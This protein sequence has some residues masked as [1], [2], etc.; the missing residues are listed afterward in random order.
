MK[1]YKYLIIMKMI[2]MLLLFSVVQLQAGSFA[3]TVRIKKKNSPIV[4]VFREIKKQTGYTVLCKSEII[5]N[6]PNVSV[7]FNN[8]SLDRALNELLSPRGLNY[9]KEGN[10]IIV[11]A[12]ENSGIERYAPLTNVGWIAE[13]SPV[14]GKITD[15]D[16]KVLAGVSVAV[17]GGKIATASDANGNY[18]IAASRGAILVFSFVG[19]ERKEVEVN[20]D[21]LNVNMHPSLSN[22]EEVVVTGY[23]TF[24]KSDY[25]GSASTIRTERMSD[26]PAVDFSTMLQGNAPGV[27]VNSLSGQ[28]GGS[29][30]IRIRGM[31]SINAVNRPLFVIDGVPVMSGDISSSSSNNAGLDVMSTLSNADI[32][33]ITV[34]KDAAAASLYG[35]RAAGGVILITTKSGKAG[36]PVFSFKGDYGLSSQATDFREVMNG[37]QRREML[38][39]GLRNKARYID[40]LTDETLIENFAQNNIDKYAPQPWSGWTD[41]KKELFRRNS[42]FRNADLSA[43][44]GDSKVS[45]YTSLGYTNQTGLS[46]QSGFERLT[47]RLNVKY[48]MSDKL[49]LGANIL[50]S[51]VNQDV[52]SEGGTYTSPIYS[53]RHKLTASE[54]VYNEDG[55]FFLDFFSNGPRNPK[56]SSLYNYRR[57]KADRS[58]N[59][60]FANYKFMDGLVFNTTF[61]LDHTTTRYNSWSDPRTSDG[62]KTNG[63]LSTSFTDYNQ[64]VWRNSLTYTKTFATKHHLDVLGGYEVNRYRRDGMDGAKD[65][66]PSVEK[67]VLSNG[68]VLTDLSGSNTEWRLLSYLSRVNY[69]YN[70]KY[71]L[72]GSVR[73]DGSSRIHRSSRWGTFWSLSGAWKFTKENFMASLNDVLTDGKLRVSYGTNGTLPSSYFTYMDLTGFGFPYGNNPGIRETQIGNPNLRWEKQ[74]NL[75]IGLDVRLFDRLGLTFEW[76]R[77]QSSDLLNDMPTSLTTGFG[78]YLTNIGAIR[79]SGIE[80]DLNA[81][82]LRDKAFKWNA[83]LNFGMNKNKTIALADGSEELRDGTSIHRIGQPWYSCY[84]IEFAGINR[85]TGVPQYY[86]NDPSNLGSRDITE[87]YTKANRI[88]YKSVDPKLIGGFTN[89]FRY[90]MFDL[91]FTWTYSLGGNSYDSGASKTELGGKTGYDNIPQYYERRWQKPGDETDIE[92]FMVGNTYDM[93]SVA[94]TRRLHSTDHIRLKNMTFGISLPQQIARRLK[95]SN[96]R[97]YCSGVNLL[98]FAAYK[99]YDPEVPVNGTVYFE[100]PKLK[101]VTFG[102]DVKF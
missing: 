43:S 60:V 72:G 29:T 88:L 69:N 5:S 31:G 7:D 56:A 45:Y 35:S 61:S 23:G 97:A 12:G 100:S 59:T 80:V 44:G 20:G 49:E 15:Q 36:K 50:Y 40:K 18:T 42:P 27:Q 25:T 16:G 22:L 71:F 65:N 77:R 4:D 32:E 58:F 53:S 78:S 101:T 11:K 75:N 102:L 47:G 34:I 14:Q 92:M 99:N 3:Q 91:N 30:D 95:V 64:M 85:E 76:Y 70:D 67:I 57:E 94:N 24:K 41:W 66:F 68:S 8:V 86:V 89:T 79:N 19:Y 9:I 93:S 2:I 46:Y 84:L 87:D 39:E 33:Q 74:N 13:Q 63:S 21:V 10:S 90:K 37:P 81:D 17:K 82:I 28:P 62:E 55:T 96:I 1:K 51:N 73:M 6:S 54:P 98:T 48:K 83:S 52:N 26:V 38:L